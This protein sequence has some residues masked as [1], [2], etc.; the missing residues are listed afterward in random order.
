MGK[1]DYERSL[2]SLEVSEGTLLKKF[3]K[4]FFNMTRISGFL[5]RRCANSILS[6]FQKRVDN[7]HS[8]FII[9]IFMAAAATLI[10]GK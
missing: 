10:D 5:G 9:I 4:T 6:Y 1:V 2:L 8:A 3:C 7:A